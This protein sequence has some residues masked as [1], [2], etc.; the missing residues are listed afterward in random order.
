MSNFSEKL[1][2]L[3]SREMADANGDADRI[4]IVIERLSAALGFTIAIAARGNGPAI[5]NLLE[6]ATSYAH[7]EAVARAPFA[8]IMSGSRR[9]NS[10]G[11]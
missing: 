3:T 11:Q 1:A 5:D 4:G 10:G 2:T 9:D 8:R 6:G 7:R